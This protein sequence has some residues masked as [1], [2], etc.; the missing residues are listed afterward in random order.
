MEPDDQMGD[1]D[2]WTFGQH[3]VSTS[4]LNVLPLACLI[5]LLFLR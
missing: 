4:Q 5:T 1:L 2:W 3:V